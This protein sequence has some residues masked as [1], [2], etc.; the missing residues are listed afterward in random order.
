MADIK[1]EELL[2]LSESEPDKKGQ[3]KRLRVV[4]WIVDGESK[5]IKLEKR[6]FYKKDDGEEGT[7]KAD[8]FIL[9]DLEAIKAN[10]AKVIGIMKNPP[11]LIAQA[12]PEGTE[13]LESVNF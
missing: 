4:R 13:S 12:A 10:W 5:S 11:A 2:V 1:G 9:K 6:Q 8:G 7:G 3:T